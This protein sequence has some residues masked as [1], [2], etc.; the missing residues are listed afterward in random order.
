[1]LISSAIIEDIKIMR[2]ATPALIAY[3]YFDFKD[4]SKRGVRGLLTSVLFQLSYDSG[5]CWDV[6][7]KLYTSCRN[8]SEQPSDAALANCLKTI[9]ELPGQVPIFMIFDALDGCPSNIGTPS[10]REKVLDFVKNIVGSNHRN[11]YMCITSRP[12]QDIQAALNPM[13][14]PTFRVSVHEE[15]GQRTDINDYVRAF[16]NSDESMRRWRAEDRELVIDTLSDRAD[17]M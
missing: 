6:L 17:G 8:G 15:A 2:E 7:Y 9:L 13:T 10:A 1:M 12:E 4:A 11:L 16:V 5:L 14:S 3:H